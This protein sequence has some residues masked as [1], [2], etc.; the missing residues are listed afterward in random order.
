MNLQLKILEDRFTIHRLAPGADL[1][2]RL[3][4]VSFYSISKTDDELSIVCPESLPVASEQLEPGWAC[5]KVLGPLDFSITGILAK[6]SAIL[7]KQEISIFAISTFDTDYILIKAELL[8]LART[9]LIGSG[10]EFLA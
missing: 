7:A 4:E 9:A 1:P 2:G 6:I 10:Y 8:P 5:I 3:G